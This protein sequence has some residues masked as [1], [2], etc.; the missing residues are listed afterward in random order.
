MESQSYGYTA[1]NVR[2]SINYTYRP[3]VDVSVGGE[4][5]SRLFKALGDSGT[6]VTVMDKTIAELLDIKTEN[7]VTGKLS[8]IG[9][10]KQGFIAP[11]SLKIAKFPDKTF[12]FEVLFIE[13]LS[14][15]FD[16]ILGQQDFFRNFDVTFQKSRNIFHLQ[17]VS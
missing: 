12:N 8:G 9:A 2:G 16:V 11:V 4:K 5:E 13:N 1:Q 15:N 17:L 14:D 6:E 3:L 7:R 10:W